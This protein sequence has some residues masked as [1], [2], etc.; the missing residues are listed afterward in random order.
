MKLL[1][2]TIILYLLFSSAAYSQFEPSDR[3]PDG[4]ESTWHI[5]YKDTLFH[6]ISSFPNST[7]YRWRIPREAI[8]DSNSI[9][10]WET[11]SNL[12][13]STDGAHF[14]KINKA[15]GD[16]DWV[17]SRTAYSML[18][19]WEY[20]LTTQTIQT[21]STITYYGFRATRPPDT[22]NFFY[23]WYDMLP[24][25]L[26]LDKETG[27]E[28]DFVFN[29][30]DTSIFF[31]QNSFKP[32]YNKEENAYYRIRPS[33][34]GE[35]KNNI[36]CDEVKYTIFKV[37]D[38][39]TVIDPPVDVI[40]IITERNL[41]YNRGSQVGSLNDT[42]LFVF[43]PGKILEPN[44]HDNY[45][46]ELYKIGAGFNK[47]LIQSI[48]LNNYLFNPPNNTTP[49]TIVVIDENIVISQFYFSDNGKEHLFFRWID[50]NGS[51]LASMDSLGLGGRDIQ[52]WTSFISNEEYLY[53]STN[54][55]DD[56]NSGFEIFSIGKN[57]NSLKSIASW[58]LPKELEIFISPA[59][60]TLLENGDLL[61]PIRFNQFEGSTNFDY[62]RLFL[63]DKSL[64]DP[65][66]N[67]VEQ[68]SI[69]ASLDIFPNPST[70]IIHFGDESLVGA[71]VLVTDIQGRPMH[72]ME[73][74][75]DTQLDLDHLPAGVY[76]IYVVKDQYI[77][78]QKIILVE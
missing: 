33:S 46:Y 49:L 36:I 13:L 61:M 57:E 26:T 75:D 62:H 14:Y 22:P 43:K 74:L 45:I 7:P 29:P 24:C 17:T 73:R 30:L 20:W 65:Q 55:E 19:H 56:F 78:S 35:I 9:Y 1:T 51:I 10:Y 60:S 64:L 32:F 53:F 38:D 63:Y 50:K 68:P 40:E 27:K 31:S 47:S 15:S 5:I 58:S 25:K 69:S 44:T 11:T 37:L 34:F 54:Y 3:L 76:V 41:S 52:Y 48:D 2:T 59:T 42:L 16:I 71:R 67:T 28:L 72:K 6:P 70:G 12:G 23:I 39:M 18:S 77:G 66:V 4:P 8:E 21:D